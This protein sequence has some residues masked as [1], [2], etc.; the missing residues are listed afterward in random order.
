MSRT[1][2]EVIDIVRLTLGDRLAHET[3][4]QRQPSETHILHS[5]SGDIYFTALDKSACSRSSGVICA[6]TNR[7]VL[8]IDD[9]E[10]YK[11]IFRW[12]HDMAG[13]VAKELEIRTAS[14]QPDSKGAPSLVVLVRDPADR[15]IVA[16][17]IPDHGP[18]N[19]LSQPWSMTDLTALSRS[20]TA[21]AV[22]PPQYS[23]NTN[24]LQL[25][26]MDT[27]DIPVGHLSQAPESVASAETDVEIKR[28]DVYQGRWAWIGEKRPVMFTL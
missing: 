19:F 27:Q 5:T 28:E 15:S 6:V 22:L 16:V 3:D 7:E 12:S 10:R 2:L 18:V 13:G 20:A 25:C 14:I 17:R 8:W 26:A 23:G 4:E 9:S 24:C 21:L 1:T 11:P